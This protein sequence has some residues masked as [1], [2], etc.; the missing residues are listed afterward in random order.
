VR[1]L[2]ASEIAAQLETSLDF[3]ETDLHDVPARQ[4][5]MRAVLDHSW[6]LLAALPRAVIEALSVFRGGFTHKATRAV[7]GASLPELRALVDRSLIQPAEGGRFE[8]HELLR[9]YAAEKLGQTPAAMQAARDRHAAYY[10]SALAA[11]EGDLES[12]R[13]QKAMAEMDVEIDN[14]RAAWDWAVGQRKPELIS[15]AARGF[16]QYYSR[17]WRP[18]EGEAV[19]R[20]AADRLRTMHGLGAGTD[21]DVL[22]VLA[23]VLGYQ[24]LFAFR[25][26][27]DDQVVWDLLAEGLALVESP[28][29][30]GRDCGSAEAY[31]WFIRGLVEWS[32]PCLDESKRSLER[33]LTLFRAV[34]DRLRVAQVVG[35]LGWLSGFY[36][37]NWAQARRDLEESA[38]IYRELGDAQW[39]AETT[40]HLGRVCALEGRLD[41]AERLLREA[42]ARQR[43]LGTVGQSAW[44]GLCLGE[45]LG[46]AGRYADSLSHLNESMALWR[47]LRQDDDALCSAALG[48]TKLHMGQ[49]G[50]ARTHLRAALQLPPVEQPQ[51]LIDLGRL[52]IRDG[53]LSEARRLFLGVLA[54]QE[55]L[56]IRTLAAQARC[57]L[58]YAAQA[59][60]A[61]EEAQHNLV[62]ALRWAA[63]SGAFRAVVE[64]LPASALMLVNQG[65]VEQ[66]VEIYALACTYGHVA[67][68]QWYEDVVGQPVAEAAAALPPDVVAA[69]QER[70]RARD[71]QATLEELIAEWEN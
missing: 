64:A 57:A 55:Q 52:A 65:K 29:I 34:G 2:P 51:V 22:E 20:G 14:A 60:D 19:F 7:A 9:Q 67:N 30:R 13:Q 42:L 16:E 11:W 39:V 12:P 36:T 25:V 44:G 3:I 48:Y 37:D 28:E 45:A 33:S 66:A 47:D 15:Q 18:R 53:E 5:S 54:A 46:W 59:P 69:A 49:Y 70:G 62:L 24:A 50:E 71:V 17:Q 31:L 68:S 21:G 58:V 1:L 61:L 40:V 41:E 10:A 6:N 56:G 63:Q 32:T 27:R 4:R 23:R 35:A 26:P 43:E 8:L 38:S